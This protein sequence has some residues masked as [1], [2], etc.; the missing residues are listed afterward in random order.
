M[1]TEYHTDTAGSIHPD[2][3]EVLIVESGVVG[4]TYVR[5]DV[6][7]ESQRRTC[8]SDIETI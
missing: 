5:C 4:L 7:Q 3:W 8:G 2:E 1:Y 6:P